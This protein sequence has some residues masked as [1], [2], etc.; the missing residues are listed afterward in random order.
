MKN[1]FQIR[2]SDL[3]G[4]LLLLHKCIRTWQIGNESSCDFVLRMSGSKLALNNDGAE[5]RISFWSY[6]GRGFEKNLQKWENHTNF[7]GKEKGKSFIYFLWYEFYNLDFPK[8]NFSMKK[9]WNLP[10][11]RYMNFEWPPIRKISFHDLIE[12]F[13]S[14]FDT[15]EHFQ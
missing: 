1:S 6:S 4:N 5:K 14:I 13:S 15:D 12:R 7:I 9:P 3:K 10:P 2:Q 8:S 11:N